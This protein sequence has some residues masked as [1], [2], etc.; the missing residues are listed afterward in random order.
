MNI[1]SM[2]IGEM[3]LIYGTLVFI[4]ITSLFPIAW[5][6]MTSLKS[7]SDIMVIP[8]SWFAPEYTLDNLRIL[9]ETVRPE[10][11]VAHMIAYKPIY[12]G[13]LNSFIC[14]TSATIL[15]I[16]LSTLAGYAFGR[17]KIWGDSVLLVSILFAQM[18]PQSIVIIPFYKFLLGIGLLNTYP[19]LIFSYLTI[20]VPFSVWLMRAAFQELPRTL[21]EAAYIDGCSR[22]RTFWKIALPL[23]MPAIASVFIYNFLSLW[24]EFMFGYTFMSSWEMQ[25][26]G[27]QIV[28][29][30][31]DVATTHWGVTMAASIWSMI[32]VLIMALIFQKY[33]IRGLL[34]GHAKG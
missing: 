16:V 27:V 11:T 10:I 14:S 30:S 25:P 29:I 20:T 13:I 1:K 3:I 33:L 23:T 34:S 22:F 26:V 15:A 32:P 24:S 18:L 8:P 5:M 12:T 28:N 9:Y 2:K 6:F 19:G 7:Y 31:T 21:E 17:F 4:A